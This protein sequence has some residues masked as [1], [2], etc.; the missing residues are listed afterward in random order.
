MQAVAVGGLQ[1]GHVEAVQEAGGVGGRAAG[2][3][4]GQADGGLHHV[5]VVGGGP[6]PGFDHLEQQ[7][8]QVA[9]RQHPQRQPG[10]IRPDRH[11]PRPDPVQQAAGPLG[12]DAG[13]GA[14]LAVQRG[15]QRARRPPGAVRRPGRRRTS[16]PTAAS[17]GSSSR[18]P[19]NR[20]SPNGASRAGAGSVWTGRQRCRT[21]RMRGPGHDLAPP[22]QQGHRAG[23]GDPAARGAGLAAPLPLVEQDRAG[24][25]VPGQARW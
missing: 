21:A 6:V 8:G 25:A 12:F 20:R 3:G 5:A 16:R 24:R 1:P 17:S 18:C 13:V 19:R 2:G 22:G 15:Q 10:L 7:H 14:A 11:P 4:Q 9:G 23:R